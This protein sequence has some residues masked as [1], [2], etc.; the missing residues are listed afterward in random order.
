[1][2]EMSPRGG[3]LLATF[4]AGLLVGGIVV[5]SITK[6]KC[7]DVKP[8]PSPVPTVMLTAR[9]DA[10]RGNG[11]ALASCLYEDGNPDGVPCLWADPDTGTVVWVSSA[12]YRN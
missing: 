4:M 9:Q 3:S 11:T 7:D 12:E 5:G 1:M 6:S 8:S 10:P 2:G